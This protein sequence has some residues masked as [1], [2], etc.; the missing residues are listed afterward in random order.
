MYINNPNHMK[1]ISDQEKAQSEE[2]HTQKT[3]VGKI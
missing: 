1:K 2:I 3:E